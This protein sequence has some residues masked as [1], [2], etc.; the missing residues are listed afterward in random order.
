[1]E[2]IKYYGSGSVKSAFAVN[3]CQNSFARLNCILI[4]IH[5]TRLFYSLRLSSKSVY[6]L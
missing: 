6:D 2:D 4:Q 5:K 3:S 1:M